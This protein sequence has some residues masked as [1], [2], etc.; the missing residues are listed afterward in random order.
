MI[1]VRPAT[2]SDLPW[3]LDRLRDLDRERDGFYFGF[4]DD[5]YAEAFVGNLI[6]DH[7]VFVSEDSGE[8]TGF[9]SGMIH[10]HPF[11]PATLVRTSMFWYV[12]PSR[13]GGR[14]ALKL[15]ESFSGVRE[16]VG[17]PSV[18]GIREGANVSERSMKRLGFEVSEKI[19]RRRAM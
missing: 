3:L 16:S 19:Y 7:L 9:I 14:S 4:P 6:K 1:E 18:I 8:L 15:L 2:S 17:V 13:R 5:A 12:L 11:N 10:P